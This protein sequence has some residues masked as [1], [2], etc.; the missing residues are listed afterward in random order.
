MKVISI[1]R[2]KWRGFFTYVDERSGQ[3]EY[4]EVPFVMT[5]ECNGKVFTGFRVD[6]ETKDVFD[7]PIPVRG[8]L[9]KGHISFRVNYPNGVY[10]NEDAELK[11]I[12]LPHPGIVYE[13]EWFPEEKK[14]AGTW[15]TDH[16]RAR[17]IYKRNDLVF[18]K[19][20]WEMTLVKNENGKFDSGADF[21][22]AHQTSR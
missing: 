22:L 21:L 17:E 9:N 12:D 5:S 3:L 16:E 7:S 2:R 6:D 8:T 11:S 10:A 14:Y 15:H 13:G 20:I 18:S 4:T 1:T 19:G